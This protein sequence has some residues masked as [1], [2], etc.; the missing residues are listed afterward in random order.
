MTRFT[1]LFVGLAFFLLAHGP[2]QSQTCSTKRLFGYTV[3]DIPNGG[4]SGCVFYKLNDSTDTIDS[5]EIIAGATKVM[6]YISSEGG[7]TC[8]QTLSPGLRE[9]WKITSVVLHPDGLEIKTGGPA[10]YD[11]S[12]L[13]STSPLSPMP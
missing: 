11:M 9:D 7:E 2:V 5:F 6:A 1:L 4:V 13:P 12:I 10:S 3:C 8:T